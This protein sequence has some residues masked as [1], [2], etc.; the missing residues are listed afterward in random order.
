MLKWTLKLVI[1]L[2]INLIPTLYYVM[3]IMI[4]K[5]VWTVLDT[6]EDPEL[7]RL[8]HSLPQTVLATRAD[9]T[10]T[11][12]PYSFRRW[13]LWAEAKEG[14]N[15][16]PVQDM[17]FALYLQHLEESMASKTAVEEPVNAILVGTS[18]DRDG[19]H[20]NSP[21]CV[22]SLGRL[23]TA[24]SKANTKKSP[25]PPKCCLPWSNMRE[26][27]WRTYAYVPWPCWLFLPFYVL[28]SS[29][30]DS[31]LRYNVQCR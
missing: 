19:P 14:I 29:P 13:K 27:R 28:R 15:V 5:W 22:H 24:A 21:F 4:G 18:A 6:L 9:S 26:V 12:Y 3:A 23:T 10:T 30:R 1:I 17:Q 8:A 25:S 20:C 16:F 2:K 11:K 7:Q 31:G